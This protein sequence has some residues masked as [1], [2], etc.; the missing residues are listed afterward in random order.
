MGCWG[1]NYSRNDRII[2]R[3]IGEFNNKRVSRGIWYYTKRF[4]REN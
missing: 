1:I 4:G 3:P 2:I